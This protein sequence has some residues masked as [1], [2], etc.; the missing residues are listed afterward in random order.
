[1]IGIPYKERGTPPVDADCWT[2]VKHYHRE[3]FGHA[4]PDY[5]YEIGELFTQSCADLMERAPLGPHWQP[6]SD[7]Q[8]GDVLVFR[9]NGQPVHCGVYI[10]DGDF[11]HSLKGRMSC[12]EHLD[13]AHWQKRLIGAYRWTGN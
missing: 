4:L 3:V 5:F 2:L 7:Y 6:V 1:M 12:L 8:H 13:P 10:G 11:L 9:V